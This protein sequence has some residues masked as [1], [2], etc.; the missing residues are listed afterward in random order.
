MRRSCIKMGSRW[1]TVEDCVRSQSESD[2]AFVDRHER[3]YEAIRTVCGIMI[4]S[5][6]RAF[7]TNR[8]LK[9]HLIY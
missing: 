3:A 6:V 4:H 7:Q 1:E 2:Q 8:V 9:A 5:E